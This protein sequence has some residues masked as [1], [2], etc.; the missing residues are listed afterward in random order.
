[1]KDFLL[2]CHVD[3]M[4]ILRASR[5]WIGKEMF[6]VLVSIWIPNCVLSNEHMVA[7]N[8]SN[9]ILSSRFG[10]G[11]PRRKKIAS[12][13]ERIP[14]NRNGFMSARRFSSAYVIWEVGGRLP[15]SVR[16]PLLEEHAA[17]VQ[18]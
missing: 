10:L 12:I 2:V 6:I 3:D 5:F 14:V 18:K 7:I 8:L 9:A 4:R 16:I 17:A 13:L 1:M 15:F 11:K